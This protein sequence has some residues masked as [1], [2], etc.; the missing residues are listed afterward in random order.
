MSVSS[1]EIANAAISPEK[2]LLPFIFDPI[3]NPPVTFSWLPA[4][5]ADQVPA[6]SAAFPFERSIFLILNRLL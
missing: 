2:F 1:V 3:A 4:P 5:N 6:R